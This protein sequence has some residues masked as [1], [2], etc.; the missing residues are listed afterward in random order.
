M[1]PFLYVI[2]LNILF[3]SL[4]RYHGVYLGEDVAVKILRS[5]QLNGAPEDEFAQEVAILR[6]KIGWIIV[7]IKFQTIDWPKWKMLDRTLSTFSS[8]LV[9]NFISL[10]CFS[11]IRQKLHTYVIT[12]YCCC[13]IE[14]LF[15]F[16][17]FAER[18]SIKMLFVL[19]VRVQSFHIC[20]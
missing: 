5:E 6:S 12:K 1:F 13:L 18:F 8:I 10:P 9:Y 4:L 19:L 7:L 15:T 16:F 2:L 11:N 14:P 17:W 20:V 3:F